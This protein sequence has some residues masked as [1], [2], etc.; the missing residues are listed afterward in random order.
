MNWPLSANIQK[1]KNVDNNANDGDANGND[2]S[3]AEL[4]ECTLLMKYC[5]I[6]R[7]YMLHGKDSLEVD[8]PY[9]V[10]DEQRNI[11]RFSKSTFVLGRS[12]TG[13]TTVLITKLIQN[14][15][16]HRK[17]VQQ[18]YGSGINANQEQSKDIATETERP[19][20]R[21][22]FVTLSGGLC[23]KVQHHV[24]LLKRYVDSVIILYPLT[25]NCLLWLLKFDFLMHNTGP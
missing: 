7:D 21:Q 15:I 25:T 11:I 13:K 22:L 24:S 12:G 18:W 6:S 14:E 4:E 23:K 20:L 9:E 10:T 1:F 19:V 16:L 3:E 8:L 17:G 2:R 5:S